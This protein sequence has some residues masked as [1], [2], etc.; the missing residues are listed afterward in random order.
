LLISISFSD[1]LL[2][3]FNYP[4]LNPA[5]LMNLSMINNNLPATDIAAFSHLVNLFRLEIG[6]LDK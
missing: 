2:T 1:N 3:S 6:N 4:I 5:T